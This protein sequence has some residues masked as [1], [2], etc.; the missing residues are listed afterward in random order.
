[1]LESDIAEK[2]KNAIELADETRTGSVGHCGRPLVRL[3]SKIRDV[4][5][6]ETS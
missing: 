3:I 2:T 5:V 1:M 6:V 4:A